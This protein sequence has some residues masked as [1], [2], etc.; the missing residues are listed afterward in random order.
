ME[1]EGALPNPEKGPGTS[2]VYWP[3]F[4]LTQYACF[5]S[6]FTRMLK[7][8]GPWKRTSSIPVSRA[9]AR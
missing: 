9:A 2:T 4:T 1:G 8:D 6:L 3:G 7:D 5:A